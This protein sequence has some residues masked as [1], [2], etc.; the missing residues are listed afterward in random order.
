IKIEKRNHQFYIKLTERGKK[1]AGWMQIDELKI[2]KSKK[3][4]KKWRIVIF[5]IS[6]LKTL[7]RNAFRGKLKE[8]EF[9]PLQKSVWVSPHRCKDEVNLL[10][11]FFGL[12]EKE[13]RLITANDIEDDGFLRK[14]FKI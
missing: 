14:T 13:V 4:D 3:W 7:H 6:Q 12:N 9:Y 11:V 8:L 1:K 2:K 5:D 10:R